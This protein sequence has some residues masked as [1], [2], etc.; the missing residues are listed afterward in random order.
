LFDFLTSDKRGCS[1]SP[2]GVKV[3]NS[4]FIGLVCSGQSDVEM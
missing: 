3:D 1:R 4:G 2:R